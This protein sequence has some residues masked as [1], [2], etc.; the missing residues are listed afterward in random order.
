MCLNRA[1]AMGLTPDPC[2][3]VVSRPVLRRGRSLQLSVDNVTV[4]GQMS[5][6][7]VR[8]ELHSIETGIM[9][10][11]RFIPVVPSN[12]VGH[13]QGLWFNGVPYLDRC[14][15]GDLAHCE[16]NAA[17]AS[18]ASYI[19]YV[20]D[21]GDGPSL[22]KGNSERQL[23][24]DQWHSVAVSRDAHNLHTLK[25]DSRTVTQHSSGARSLDLKGELYIGGVE[26]SRYSSLPKLIASR[27]GFQ[28]CLASVDLNG[29]L[30]DLTSND[31][32]RE[33]LVE[34]GCDGP[35]TTCVED[36]CSN[37]GV[38]LQQWEGFSCDCTMTSYGGAHCRILAVVT[39]Q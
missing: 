9:T 38:C 34:R 8:L 27:D 4:E 33:G 14:Q 28:G 26:R 1:V 12:F 2:S 22:M 10:E 36:S 6:A 37:Q 29:R 24:D 25:I 32:L 16:L 21:L 13:L 39:V 11:R 30:P 7:H 17:R 5:G 3:P 15:N 19:H 18:G 20:F 31:L 35:S 23:N